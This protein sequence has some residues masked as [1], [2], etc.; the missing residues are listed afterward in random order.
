MR[1]LVICRAFD[2]ARWDD[3]RPG[4]AVQSGRWLS[5]MLSRLPGEP[6][7]A[8]SDGPAGAVGFVGAVISDP[9]AYEAYNPW[10]IL[11]RPEP[12]FEEVHA[13]GPVA[14]GLGDAPGDLLP[15]AVLAAP[16]YIGDPAGPGGADPEAVRRI[17]AGVCGWAREAGLATVSVLYTTPAGSAV[18]EPAVAA[19][20]GASFDL[21]SRGVLRVTWPDWAGRL[22]ALPRRRREIQR[23]L[24][25]LDEAGG[26]VSVLDPRPVFDEVI[27][28]R[29]ALLRWYG[30]PVEESGERRRLRSLVDAFGAGALLFATRLEG[31][32]VACALFVAHRRTLQNVYAGTTSEGRDTAF[33]HLAAT[34]YEP[35]RFVSR[36]RFD[37]IDYSVGHA[38]TKRFQGC[39]FVPMRGHLISLR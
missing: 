4:P 27:E 11:R 38:G 36:E 20:G 24:R 33:A 29:C 15:S 9:E 2:P 32:L 37:L 6:L 26:T 12:V 30:Q 25:R 18:V 22:A 19:L 34:Y 17:L 14:A 23:Q 35:A 1:G 7:V 31:R 16:G 3:L 10:M 8:Y 21:T 28:A 39:E 5:V 13:R